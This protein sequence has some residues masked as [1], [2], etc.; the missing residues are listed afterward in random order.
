MRTYRKFK[1]IENHKC[2]DYL[3]QITNT[4][5]RMT[6]TKLQ[7]SNRKLTIETDRY[8]RSYKRPEERMCLDLFGCCLRKQGERVGLCSQIRETFIFSCISFRITEQ[9]F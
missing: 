5:I 3:H 9:Y 8:L 2:E 7:L 6:L 1:T 4:R